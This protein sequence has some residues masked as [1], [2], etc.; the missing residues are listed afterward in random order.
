MRSLGERS[1]AE[2]KTWNASGNAGMLE[3]L[4]RVPMLAFLGRFRACAKRT[5]GARAR[6]RWLFSLGGAGLFATLPGYA[7]AGDPSFEIDGEAYAGQTTGAWTCGPKGVARYGGLG[8]R[9]RIS[10]RPGI[11]ERGAG[12]YGTLGGVAE[13]ERVSVAGCSNEANAR[14]DTWRCQL[15]RQHL[16]VGVGALTGYRSQYLGFSLGLLAY[17]GYDT[18]SSKTPDWSS[19]PHIELDLGEEDRGLSWP[20]GIGS[21]LVSTYRRPA[22]IY[23]GPRITH[24]LFR[25]EALFGLYRSGPASNATLAL[26]TDWTLQFR[27]SEHLWLGP[28]GSMADG[29]PI[30]GE[31]GLRAGLWY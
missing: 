27:I 31:I 5:R 20:L 30:D 19:W 22:L 4:A 6:R 11:A 21:P 18:I 16:M 2:R 10:E 23:S 29:D 1:Y 26:R 13:Y 8:A 17:Q 15:P 12:Y 9:A 25:V 14:G 7:S 3:A 28:H 24:R